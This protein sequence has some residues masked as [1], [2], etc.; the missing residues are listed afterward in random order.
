M[1]KKLDAESARKLQDFGNKTLAVLLK[2]QVSAALQLVKNI[3]REEAKEGGCMTRINFFSYEKFFKQEE[4]RPM[5]V[6]KLRSEGY[7]VSWDLDGGG[8]NIDWIKKG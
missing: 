4:V 5:V 1:A 2:K 3:I 7:T 8:I 6:D